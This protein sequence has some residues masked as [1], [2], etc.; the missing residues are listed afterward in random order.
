ML[1]LD[2]RKKVRLVAQMVKW[3]KG[4]YHPELPMPSAF[5]SPSKC[6]SA[7]H[8]DSLDPLRFDE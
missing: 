4:R 7:S 3:K 5:Q 6:Y 1:A 2:S 8:S